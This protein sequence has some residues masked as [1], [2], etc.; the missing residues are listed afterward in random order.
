ME[1]Q[2]LVILVLTSVFLLLVLSIM[3]ILFSDGNIFAG[4]NSICEQTNWL[5]RWCS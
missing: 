2:T 5:F 3:L 4:P 1:T